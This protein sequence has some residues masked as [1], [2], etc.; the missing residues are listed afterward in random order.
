V[1]ADAEHEKHH[2]DLRKLPCDFDVGDETRRTWTDHD[3]GQEI[4]DHGRQLQA[5]RKKSQD[6]R[7]TEGCCNRRYQRY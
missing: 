4:A 6:E 1:Q 7:E 3:A 2:A 5:H